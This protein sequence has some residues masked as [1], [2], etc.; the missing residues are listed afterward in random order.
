MYDEKRVIDRISWIVRSKSS[1][2][3][4]F[5]FFRLSRRYRNYVFWF[6]KNK[7]N[8]ISTILLKLLYF[9][10]HLYLHL[11]MIFKKHLYYVFLSR[12]CNSINFFNFNQ[13]NLRKRYQHSKLFFIRLICFHVYCWKRLKPDR[14]VAI[15]NILLIN[16]LYCALTRGL[17][18]ANLCFF[19]LIH[20]QSSYFTTLY[21]L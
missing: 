19:L 5:I 8:L 4:L 14:N 7:V 13:F 18:L 11:C 20:S 12:F 15:F 3:L 16:I 9:Y 10:V 2:Y 6:K 1:F 21:Y 17:L